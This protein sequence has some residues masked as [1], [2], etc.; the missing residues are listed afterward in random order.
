LA[1]RAALDRIEHHAQQPKHDS[2]HHEQHCQKHEVWQPGDC[3]LSHGA[4]PS[5]HKADQIVREVARAGEQAEDEAQKLEQDAEKRNPR[6]QAQR[7]M[8]RGNNAFGSR[9]RQRADVGR[10]GARLDPLCQPLDP[11]SDDPVQPPRQ[12]QH[13]RDGG[14]KRERRAGRVAETPPHGVRTSSLSIFLDCLADSGQMGDRE[15]RT[16]QLFEPRI[17]VGDGDH[18]PVAGHDPL[19]AVGF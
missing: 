8:Q 12:G 19:E 5:H 16:C 6:Q 1:E 15:L 17:G 10:P 3:G 14:E 7:L 4:Q 2:E 11:P 13:D 9:Q 18:Q